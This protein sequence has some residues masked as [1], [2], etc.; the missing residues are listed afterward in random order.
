MTNEII[1]VMARVFPGYERFKVDSVTPAITGGDRLSFMIV[2]NEEAKQSFLEAED[3]FAEIFLDAADSPRGNGLDLNMRFEFTFPLYKLQFFA[4][5]KGENRGQ[6]L[7][8]AKILQE[9]DMFILWL[10]DENKSLIN[11]LQVPWDI[12]KQA[13]TVDKVLKGRQY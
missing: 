7:S 11:V 2:C 1:E 12:E 6:Q 3:I 10:V 4:V 9:V 8:L 5:I 13:D